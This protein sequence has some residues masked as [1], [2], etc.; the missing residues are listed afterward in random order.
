MIADNGL[1]TTI[2]KKIDHFIPEA[3]QNRFSSM[4]QGKGTNK[5]TQISMKKTDPDVDGITGLAILTDGFFTVF[6]DKYNELTD[7]LRL[8]TH[9]LFDV[10]TIA[11]TA[12]NTYRTT[13]ALETTVTIPLDEYMRKCGIPQTKASKDKTRR[14]VKEDL[15]ILYNTSIEWS[16]PSGKEIKDYMKMRIITAQ[17]IKNGKIIVSFSPEIVRYLTNAYIMQYP[18]G[19]LKISEKNTNS[20][21]LG[22]K[23]L[24]H[25]SIN[26][27]KLK[28]T[29][30]II[31]VR[32]LLEATPELPDY[33][34]ISKADRHLSR[35]I[36]EPFERDMNALSSILAW[37]YCNSG[38][39]PL[40][41][42]QVNDFN[43]S[44]F[45]KRYVVFEVLGEDEQEE[46]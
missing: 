15:D 39:E 5:L 1:K 8:S 12:Q 13:G 11:L 40:T 32:A 3:N 9:K 21:Y 23:L 29:A 36:I 44:A 7:G 20:Y 41:D 27:N 25:H 28:G 37:E 2:P 46:L 14:R 35:R 30:N 6:I 18:E 42:E 26:N 16:E 34:E 22:K 24:L 31:S 33:E 17:G 45:I 38:G 43:Y 4:L 19:I 10:F